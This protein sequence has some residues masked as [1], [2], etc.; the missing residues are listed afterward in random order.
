M[1][2]SLNAG[3][4]NS[5]FAVPS[6]IVDRYLLIAG[7][8]SLKLILFLLRHGGERFTAEQLRMELGFRRVGELEDAALFWVERGI[9]RAESGELTPASPEN[10]AA[11]QP[12][13]NTAAQPVQEKKST[14]RKVDSGSAIVYSPADIAGRIKQDP[15]VNYL[16]SEAQTLYGRPLRNPE[17]Q[18]VISLVDY[19]GL[20][21]EVSALLLKY[22]FSIG[23]STPGYIKSVAQTW[24]DEEITDAES[25]DRMLAKLERANSTEETLRR[26]MGMQTKFV[27]PQLEFIKKW[28]VEWGFS[29]EMIL[30]AHE[31]SQTNTGSL[32][33]PYMNKIL[34][35]W[36]SEGIATLEAAEKSSKE[37]KNS[38][39]TESKPAANAA[40]NTNS[41][42]N[43]SE[44]EQQIW[45]KYKSDSD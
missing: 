20:P 23:K 10:S 30:L 29:T 4:W 7:E 11:A 13:E 22:C 15:A 37:H 24:T 17:S 31:I 45:L 42:L 35:N 26:E 25:A 6:S 12:A 5:V 28:S 1:E 16:F 34:M 40:G 41:S 8:N 39:Q 27:K 18:L 44:L 19:Y 36:H 21:A 2:F 3:E 9:I 43:T 32:N 33:F 38:R 14:A